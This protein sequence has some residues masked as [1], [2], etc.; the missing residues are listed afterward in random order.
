MNYT[1]QS[2]LLVLSFLFVVFA[3]AQKKQIP[4]KAMQ[5]ADSV[6]TKMTPDQR[7]GQLFMLTAPPKKDKKNLEFISDHIKKQHIGGILFS[8]G[9][10][11]EQAEVTNYAQ[12]QTLIPLFIALD[13]EWG[14]AMRLKNTPRYPYNMTAA[15]ARNDSL[16][17][18]YGV[19]VGRECKEMGI[20]IQFAPV[21]DVN[22]NAKNPVINTRSFGE[23]PE[24]VTRNATAYVQGIQSKGIIAVGKHF[25]GH[26]DTNE[27]SHNEL[28]I[29]PHSRERLN[30]VELFPFKRLIDE[31]IDGIMTGH[32]FV[33]AIDSS[34]TPA[35]LSPLVI[36]ELLKKELGF[37][38]LIFTDGLKM[39][40]VSNQPDIAIRAILAGNDILLDVNNIPKEIT[41][42][43]KAIKE[44]KLSQ[45]LIDE[46][47]KKIL[48]YK[49]MSGLN[50]YQAIDTTALA[51]RINIPQAKLI[52]EQ[53]SQKAVTVLKNKNSF[54]PIKNLSKK[55]AAISLG[56][57]SDTF[58]STLA[59]YGDVKCFS[60]TKDPLPMEIER[61][62]AT[63]DSF[64]VVII[65]IHHKDV[66]EKTIQRLGR[67][68]YRILAFFTSPYALDNFRNLIH[69]ST[70]CILGYENR[71]TLQSLS[72]QAIFG[73]IS[74]SGKLPVT[75]AELFH[76]DTGLTLKKSR[77]GYG[78]P[79]GVG[80]SS[81]K[82]QQIDS[83]AL[84]AI[85]KGMM[86]GCQILV[87]KNGTVIYQR[88]FGYQDST[89]QQAVKN[90]DLYD[91]ASL[92][93][94]SATL[95]SLMKLYD[96]NR[97][98]LNKKIATYLP[99]LRHTNKNQLVIKDILFHQAG[100]PSFI[101]FYEIGIDK[102]AVS[103]KLFQNYKT[104]EYALQT[105][106]NLYASTKY[107]YKDNLISNKKDD[108]HSYPIG[109]SLYVANAFQDSIWNKIKDAPLSAKGKYLYSD[110]GFI[111]LQKLVEKLSRK[112]LNEYADNTF[113][114]PLGANFIGYL[115]LEKFKKEQIIPTEYDQFLRKQLLRGYVHDP[116]AAFMGGVA[117][118]AGLFSNANDLAKL[119]QLYLNKGTYGNKRYLSEETCA[120]FTET[121]S[122]YS[123]RG[124]G[125]DR[126]DG[127]KTSQSNVAPSASAETYGH[128]GFTGTCLWIDPKEN[129]IYIFLSNRV[130]PNSW[131]RQLIDENIRTRIQQV[132]YD[133]IEKK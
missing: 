1:R 51:D 41:S 26:G 20:H 11:K 64:D 100:L 98:E 7:I 118:H 73:G 42:V 115:P 53:L 48:Y 23:N 10:L 59:F 68:K 94:I 90:T 6:F 113:Y 95:P 39:K 25:P 17:Y 88:S 105:D 96:E 30:K 55:I 104:E 99:D 28:A 31:G 69:E 120:L 101:P 106:K 86:P 75:I 102:K 74:T 22:S 84:N 126:S 3:Q 108:N 97:F 52:D 43:K 24:E 80:I 83:I 5:W 67:N 121:K 65:G 129:L 44:G 127:E 21:L 13:G 4:L 18:F 77:L 89:K 92:T 122:P 33:P 110:I 27:D 133:E 71:S 85:K 37:D 125:F 58:L 116:N 8:E 119:C 124:L 36:N 38:G 49:Y 93:K 109:D 29:V 19:E 128:T 45:T 63:L 111:M 32:I 76:K 123:R 9:N 50:R 2:A 14:L 91:I 46:K 81:E 87:A 62:V 54:I 70:A 66:A 107:A 103:N 130:H 131:N 117:G 132:I 61:M 34:R 35:S 78:L 82:L 47:C 72:A 79:E 60:L 56:S 57:N 15:A 12:A 112:E 114:K 40:G 16:M